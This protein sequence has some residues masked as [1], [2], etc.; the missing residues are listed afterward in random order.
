MEGRQ[1]FSLT[2]RLVDGQV[3]PDHKHGCADDL[4]LLKDMASASGQDTIYPSYYL[5]WWVG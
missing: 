5:L 1:D 2:D 4:I 3:G